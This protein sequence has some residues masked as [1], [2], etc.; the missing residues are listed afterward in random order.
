MCVKLQRD[1]SFKGS[2]NFYS[3]I[4]EIASHRVKI[5]KNLQMEPGSDTLLNGVRPPQLFYFSCLW[6]A[7]EIGQV[8]TL[9]KQALS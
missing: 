9:G 3:F 6:E 4:S 8:L 5:Q 1:S 7:W 2:E